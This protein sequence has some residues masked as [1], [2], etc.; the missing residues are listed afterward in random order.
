MMDIAF[1]ITNALISYAAVAVLVVLFWIVFAIVGMSVF[2]ELLDNLCNYDSRVNYGMLACLVKHSLHCY[3]L[4][5]RRLSLSFNNPATGKLTLDLTYL[6][7]AGY[8]NFST[9]LG[10]IVISFQ[11][12]DW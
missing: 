3:A 12:C 6:G 9:F 4:P 8:P 10:S 5:D 7:V 2:G 11:V 1:T